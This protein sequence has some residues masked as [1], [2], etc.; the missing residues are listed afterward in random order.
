MSCEQREHLSSL[1]CRRL[2]SVGRRASS[3]A[4]SA[5]AP[6]ESHRAGPVTADGAPAA[7]PG[8]ARRPP[9]PTRPR[10][11]HPGKSPRDASP[12][13]LG[14]RCNPAAARSTS[15][16]SPRPAG[17]LHRRRRLR[18]R[19]DGAGRLGP[20]SPCRARRRGRDGGRERDG[21]TAPDRAERGRLTVRLRDHGHPAEDSGHPSVTVRHL[22][23]GVGAGGVPAPEI[24]ELRQPDVSSLTT[25]PAV[26]Q[27]RNHERSIAFHS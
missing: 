11:S 27:S 13:S 7:E 2:R 14:R 25:R 9:R 10:A 12:T 19:S 6:A 5:R 8:T 3:I 1:G 23:S 26:Q 21:G 15:A 4:A 16:I 17:G 24:A 18:A 22:S 20:R